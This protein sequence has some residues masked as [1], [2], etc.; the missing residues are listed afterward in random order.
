[1]AGKKSVVL[2]KLQFNVFLGKFT[3]PRSIWNHSTMDWPRTSDKSALSAHR[4]RVLRR[5]YRDS[6]CSLCWLSWL[7]RGRGWLSAPH[8]CCSAVPTSAAH[9]MP[10]IY[11]KCQKFMQNTSD[12]KTF[13]FQRKFNFNFT[14]RI[15]F[16]KIVFLRWLTHSLSLDSSHCHCIG[17]PVEVDGSM[18]LSI[19]TD[20]VEAKK[21]I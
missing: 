19:P 14:Q 4:A 6:L 18:D 12:Q 20:L 1:M 5:Y 17:F 2:Y 21:K 7:W 9:G 8:H 11:A 3:S 13:S 16:I 10:K 15:S